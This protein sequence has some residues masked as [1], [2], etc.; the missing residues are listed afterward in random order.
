MATEEIISLT[1]FKNDAAGWIKRLETQPPVILTQNGRGRAVVQNYEAWRQ[2]QIAFAMLKRALQAEVD[3]REGRAISHEEMM[4]Q[5][6]ALIGPNLA[7]AG[8][9]RKRKPRRG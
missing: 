9:T 7:E 8:P 5:V 2:E 1:A 6:D 4:R 3:H